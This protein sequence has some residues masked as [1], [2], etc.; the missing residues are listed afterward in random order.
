MDNF[1]DFDEKFILLGA[2]GCSELGDPWPVW[3][4]YAE[5]WELDEWKTERLK[6]MGGIGL[7]AGGLQDAAQRVS[8]L[9]VDGTGRPYY[10]V[11]VRADAP[12]DIWEAAQKKLRVLRLRD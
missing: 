2:E 10:L 1:D 8:D 7:G 5:P 6:A 3:V 4:R 11:A 9:C 12:A